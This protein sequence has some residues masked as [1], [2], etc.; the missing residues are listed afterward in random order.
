[1]KL[2]SEMNQWGAGICN[3][4]AQRIVNVLAQWTGNMF[5]FF[6]LQYFRLQNLFERAVIVL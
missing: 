4:I 5:Q 2:V 3:I 1:M 6:M